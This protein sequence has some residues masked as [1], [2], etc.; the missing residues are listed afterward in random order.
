MSAEDFIAKLERVTTV[1]S[2]R[3]RAIC[4]AHPSRHRTQSLA[5]RALSDGTLLIHCHAG[6]GLGQIV[7]AVGMELRDL[8]PPN[9]RAENRH[10]QRPNHW[11]SM[12]EALETLH[13]EVLL[14]AIAAGDV[15]ARRPISDTD[16]DRVA[17]SAGRIRSAIEACLR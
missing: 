7:D 3:W 2:D 10:S 11:H 12:R 5:I 14:C 13:F 8:F 6:C 16:A 9:H 4:P 17:Q 1:G 15:A